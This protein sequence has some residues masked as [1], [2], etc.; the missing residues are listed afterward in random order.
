MAP[1]EVFKRVT[2]LEEIIKAIF[3]QLIL[4][5]CGIGDGT[6]QIRSLELITSYL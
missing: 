2:E 1:T 4:M 3:E 6:K 5:P